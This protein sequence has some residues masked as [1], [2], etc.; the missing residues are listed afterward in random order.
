MTGNEPRRY[1][2]SWSQLSDWE[3]PESFRLKRLEKVWQRPAAWFAMGTAVHQAIE[4]WERTGR[5]MP[6]LDA[7]DVFHRSYSDEI[8][9]ALDE[10]PN[11]DLWM[12]SGR[13]DGG[14]D[15]TRRREIG[16]THV[17]NTIEYYTSEHPE[18]VPWTL[19]DGRLAI[20]LDFELELGSVAVRG[21]LDAVIKAPGLPLR[22]RDNKT[23]S[24]VGDPRQ[25]KLTGIALEEFALWST[26][27]EI[28]VTEGDFFMTKEGR[29]RSFDLSVIDR[30]L[31]TEMFETLDGAVQAGEF[32]PNPSPDRCRRC[33]VKDSCSYR[34]D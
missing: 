10:T 25:L 16:E 4:D 21:K 8:N 9:E 27:E 3:C 34:E 31:L 2:R 29:P 14:T 1:P 11:T 17:R 18:Q 32:P 24:K 19:A 7:I 30:S 13:Y 23:G 20:E 5:S 15:I 28:E 22:P 33:S 12:W 26:G 6:V